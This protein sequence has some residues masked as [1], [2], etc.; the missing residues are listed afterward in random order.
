MAVGQISDTDHHMPFGDETTGT[1]GPPE[2]GCRVAA[3]GR[4]TKGQT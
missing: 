2:N 3:K 1:K 4:N